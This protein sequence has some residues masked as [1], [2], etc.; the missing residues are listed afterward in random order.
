[1]PDIEFPHPI[2]DINFHPVQPM[3]AA[4]LIDGSVRIYSYSVD[5]NKLLHQ[6]DHH[7]KSCRAVTF[8][9]DGQSLNTASKDKSICLV[10]IETGKVHLSFLKAH[11]SPIYTMR[12]IEEHLIASGDDDGFVKIWDLRKKGKCIME[13]K[14]NNDFIADFD[15][16]GNSKTLLAASGDGV[17]SVFHVG[18]RKLIEKS[19]NQESELLC[20][21][22]IKGGHK[23]VCGTGDGII[24]IYSWDQWGDM[25][26]R[27][28]GHPM[29]VD[30]CTKISENVICTGSM[31]GMI[32]AVSIH[33]NRLLGVL[34][35]HGDFPIE[36]LRVS[37]F[38]LLAS[39]AH[40]AKIK[41]WD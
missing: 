9:L 19:D 5:G 12:T 18:Q 30:T 22:V 25:S 4:G 15:Y 2:F 24:N 14:E 27:F 13:V 21:S 8:S 7:K 11:S 26:D 40:D 38:N 17:L 36:K 6:F 28:P 29:S 33:P 20:V 23:V 39:C 34:G 35:D 3:I 16:V 31:D 1:P 10:N 37:N 41:F 32:R